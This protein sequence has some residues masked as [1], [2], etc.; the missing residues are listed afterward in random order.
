MVAEVEAA[1][2]AARTSAELDGLLGATVCDAGWAGGRVAVVVVV[3]GVLA[4]ASLPPDSKSVMPADQA[5]KRLRLAAS[6]DWVMPR[7]AVARLGAVSSCS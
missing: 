4:E 6:A 2:A 3:V 7:K 5:W 1:G